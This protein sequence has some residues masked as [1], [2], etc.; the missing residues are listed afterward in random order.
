MVRRVVGPD[1]PVVASYDLHAN[2]SD[3]DIDTLDAFIGY[4]PTRTWTCA[5]R[6]RIGA[7]A[8]PAYRRDADPSREGAPADHAPT[9]TMLTGKDAPNR[10]YGEM[11]DLGQ[12]L[13]Q[14]P[15]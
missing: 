5:T 11:I 2:V 12:D 4:A 15:A 9:V 7:G 8:A 3:A 14:Q 10:P 1:V 6:R 13:D